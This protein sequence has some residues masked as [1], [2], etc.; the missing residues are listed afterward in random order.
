MVESTHLFAL[1]LQ[2]LEDMLQ[3]FSVNLPIPNGRMVAEK[4]ALDSVI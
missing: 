2:L 3:L 4:E 1:M